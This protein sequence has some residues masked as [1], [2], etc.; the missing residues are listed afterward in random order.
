MKNISLFVAFFYCCSFV[1]CA[2]I[3][4]ATDCGEHGTCN[5][6][7]G[8]CV[9]ERG[10]ATLVSG[11]YC[12]E[13][14]RN[15]FIGEWEAKDTLCNDTC[16]LNPYTVT[17]YAHLKDSS[18]FYGKNLAM[19]L[20]SNPDSAIWLMSATDNYIDEK[21]PISRTLGK[22][23]LYNKTIEN[24]FQINFTAYLPNDTLHWTT[25]LRKK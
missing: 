3:D 23:R 21:T 24:G 6:M 11:K 16:R 15:Y 19:P 13:Y 10:Y 12:Q 4:C 7:D 5:E 9:C 17:F 2:I 20:F 22:I 18:L 1:A 8:S 25:I 14:A